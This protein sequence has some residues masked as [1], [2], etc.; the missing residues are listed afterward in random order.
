MQPSGGGLQGES[1]G[2]PT[3]A[4]PGVYTEGM[5]YGIALLAL[6]SALWAG[7]KLSVFQIQGIDRVPIAPGAVMVVLPD[8]SSK[9]ARLGAGFTL[10]NDP[11][12]VLTLSSSAPLVRVSSGEVPAGAIDGVNTTFTLANT[13]VNPA[14]V[15][16]WRNGLL[17]KQGTDYTITAGSPTITFMVGSIPQ[18]GDTLQASYV[19]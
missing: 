13:P 1:K 9:L 10:A 12:G 5:R 19:F 8:G 4:A 3:E 14:G 15:E 11:N 17:L 2:H 16:L 18:V 6:A 7:T